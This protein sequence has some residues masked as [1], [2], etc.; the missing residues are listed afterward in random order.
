MPGP[1]RSVPRTIAAV[2][3]IVGGFLLLVV[4]GIFAIRSYRRWTRGEIERPTFAWVMAGVSVAYLVLV[5]GSFYFLYS[6]PLLEDDFSDPSSG[7]TEQGPPTPAGYVEGGYEIED[8]SGGRLDHAWAGFI[9]GGP[10]TNV[11]VEVDVAILD[12]TDRSLV[13]IGCGNAGDSAGYGFLVAADGT[14]QIRSIAGVRSTVIAEGRLDEPIGR[15]PVRVRGECYQ[16][17]GPH[18]VRLLVDGRPVATHPVPSG[19][20]DSDTVLLLVA[21]ADGE[22]VRGR[23]DDVSAIAL[24]PSSA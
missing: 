7:W 3:G 24:Q 6:V 1:R 12:G 15:G 20:F 2:V 13:G 5:A 17:Y 11:A 21:S 18:Q 14:Y 4:P 10:R 16:G 8:R 23:F 19:I 22:L 9:W